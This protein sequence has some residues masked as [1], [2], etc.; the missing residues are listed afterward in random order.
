[1]QVTRREFLLQTGHAC[2]GYA[3]GAAAFAAGVQRFSVINA[4]AQGT[5]YKAL[6]CVFLA[7]GNDGNNVIVPLSTAGYEAY[8]SVRSGSGLAISRDALLPITPPR[9]GNPFGLHPSLVDLQTLWADQK[10]SVVCNVGPLVQPLTR[11]QY[12]SGSPRPY[13]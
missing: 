6:V 3:L 11:E 5:D 12:L 13:Q 4:L 10:L 9:I 8:A 7:G 1:M 2:L